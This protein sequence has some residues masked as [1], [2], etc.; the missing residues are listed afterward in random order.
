[1]TQKQLSTKKNQMTQKQSSTKKLPRIVLVN[2]FSFPLSSTY[3]IFTLAEEETGF[4]ICAPWMSSWIF[5]TLK[6]AVFSPITKLSA[7][8]TLDFPGKEER[9]NLFLLNNKKPCPE[10]NKPGHQWKWNIANTRLN[11]TVSIFKK[12]VTTQF[13]VDHWFL[14]CSYGR[15]LSGLN[16]RT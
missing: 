6:L 14:L 15:V 9:K 10:S 8:I 11:S 4:P 7:S 12:H 1:M 5:F 3:T 16:L 2:V 13:Y